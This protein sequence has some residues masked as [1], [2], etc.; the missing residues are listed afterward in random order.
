MAETLIYDLAGFVL[1]T[2]G[3]HLRDHVRPPERRTAHYRDR[4]DRTTLVY[5]V[6]WQAREG[7]YLFTAPPFANLWP[8]LRDGL[9]RD[10][11]KVTPR[12][13]RQ[14]KY[15]QAVLPG[16]EGAL[17]LV[18]DGVETP[19]TPRPDLSD[20]FRGRNAAVTM[21]KDNPPDWVVIWARHHVRHHGLQAVLIHD[22]CSTAYDAAD[23]AR[24]LAAVPGLDRVAVA[25]APF[26]YGTTDKVEAGEVR[27]NYLQPALLNLARTDLLRQARAV[28]NAD[29][30][31]LVLNRSG[32]SVFDVAAR[33]PFRAAR[34]PVYW[35]DPPPE[36][37]GPA[38]QTAH[39]FRLS[40]KPRTPRK[41]CA[42]PQGWLSRLG[43]WHVHHVGGELFKLVPEDKAHEVVHCRA[44]STG[45]HPFKRRHHDD[46]ARSEDPE[47]VALMTDL[48][49]SR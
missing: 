17:S 19:L 22:N 31:E 39:R 10:G 2:A 41:W 16:P 5:D 8:L 43:G 4:F 7:R 44:T 11:R 36:T 37:E 29:I 14:A 46:D 15:D 45:W 27:P 26:P 42:V 35:A 30:D 21:N 18:I 32:R 20:G 13:L 9:R 33:S 47:L 40:P 25:R 3:P 24:A 38:P 23:L 34:L 49:A 48:E 28:L 12:L 1:P 6:V